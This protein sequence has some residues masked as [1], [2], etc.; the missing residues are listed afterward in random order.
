MVNLNNC[1]DFKSILGKLNNQQLQKITDIVKRKIKQLIK[2][3]IK[4]NFLAKE[5]NLLTDE[6]LILENRP[7]VDLKCPK[8]ASVALNK[9]GITNNKQRYICKNCRTTFDETTNSPLSNT[10]LSLEKWFKYCELMILGKSI[11]QCASIVSVSVP[12]SF[13]MRHRILNVLNLALSQE[14]LTGI[15]EIDHYLLPEYF[16]GQKKKDQKNLSI[17]DYNFTENNNKSIGSKLYK[18]NYN[19]KICIQTAID[20]K[21]HILSR[22]ISKERPNLECFSKFFHNKLKDN[23]VFCVPKN[24]SF[25]NLRLSDSMKNIKYIKVQ[26]FSYRL[27][28]NYNLNT[29]DN[30][31]RSFDGWMKRFKGVAS[32]YLNN[33]LA[34]FKFLYVNLDKSDYDMTSDLFFRVVYENLKINKY[35]IKNRVGDLV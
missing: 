6:L 20:R 18:N 3:N 27:D 29:V 13:Y 19:G 1:K 9:N 16:K 24:K 12:T 21:G 25:P 4:Y 8:C 33:Y 35:N 10:K 30:Y 14:T 26:R 34:W 22:V 15:I 31:F 2:S 7:K 17:N 11:R 23:V 28:S 5:D 32:K